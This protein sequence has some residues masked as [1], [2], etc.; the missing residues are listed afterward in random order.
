MRALQITGWKSDPE[1]VETAVPE[2][3]AGQVLIKVAAAGACHS[4]LHLLYEM[5]A[6][7]ALPFTLGHENTGWVES[8]G[9]GVTGLEV[10]QPV[11]VH[12]AWGCGN[13][14]RCLEGLENYCD[15][16]GTG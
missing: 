11:A 15:K 14:P 5:E 10:G 3:G 16:A 4:D 6:P 1:L 12:G 2:P 9:G 8:L 7:W 13:C